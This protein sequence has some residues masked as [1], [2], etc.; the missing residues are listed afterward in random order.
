M[1]SAPP[2][3]VLEAFGLAA[4]VAE[5]MQ[6]GNVHDTHVVTVA[7]GR[8]VVQRVNSSVFADPHALMQNAVLTAECM[9]RVGARPLEYRPAAD[10]SL[11]A[12]SGGEVWRSY[13]YVESR[14]A[15]S[16]SIT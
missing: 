5:A 13:P 2:D 10:G 6:P 11:L 3:D 8:F 4:G 15:R 16:V 1:E 12:T 14:S 7:D 9:T